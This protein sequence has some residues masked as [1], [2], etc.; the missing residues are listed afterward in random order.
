MN[1]S[2]AILPGTDS[3][4]LLGEHI[5]TLVNILTQTVG[6]KLSL[7]EWMGCGLGKTRKRWKEMVLRS[8]EREVTQ[9]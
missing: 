7:E 3:K 9:R 8:R 4:V 5:T 6:L 1:V 2:K